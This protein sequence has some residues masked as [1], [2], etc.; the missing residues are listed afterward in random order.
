[1]GSRGQERTGEDRRGE[2]R[3]YSEVSLPG[4]GCGVVASRDITPGELIIAETP[5]ILL[6]WWI[7]HSLFPGNPARL[8]LAVRLL[9]LLLAGRRSFTWSDVSG[10][11]QPNSGTSSSSYTTRKW[12]LTRTRL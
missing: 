12:V 7:R 5:L 8:A 10:T 9:C 1:M 2:V 4:K 3:M 6:P 11:S